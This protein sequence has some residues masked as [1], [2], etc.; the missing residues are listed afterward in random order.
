MTKELAVKVRDVV[1][2]GLSHGIG[3]PEPGQMC[4]EAAV[5]FAMG[6]PHN[7]QPPCVAPVVRDCKINLNDAPW[8]SPQARAKGLEALA[9]AQLGSKGVIDEPDFSIWI[10]KP[11]IALVKEALHN[12]NVK[13]EVMALISSQERV[14]WHMIEEHFPR[15]DQPCP[16]YDRWCHVG[17]AVIT[18]VGALLAVDGE[19][20]VLAVA[21]ASSLIADPAARDAYLTRA[22]NI[23]LE[24]LKALGSPG[25]QWLDIL[26]AAA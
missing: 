18:S 22:A 24:A 2:C 13:P 11:L 3:K 12:A 1:R 8:S 17:G 4:V 26:E 25:C 19:E 20:A 10:T 16:E 23:L 21:A 7:D 15:P 9:V 14:Y 6:L 5:C